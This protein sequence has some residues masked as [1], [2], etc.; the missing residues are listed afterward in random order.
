MDTR[1]LETLIAVIEEGSLAQAARQQSLT[2]ATV[3]QRLRVL[4]EEIG[5]PLVLR[6]GRVVRPTAAATAIVASVRGILRDVEELHSLASGKNVTGQLRLGAVTSGMTGLVPMLLRTMKTDAPEVE[7]YL[8]PGYS[9]E[10]YSAVLNDRLDAAI[11]VR[12]Q[13]EVA[14]TCE[15]E[16]VREDR[17]IVVVP[18]ALAGLDYREALETQPFI[19]YDR[20]QWGGALAE[21]YLRTRNIR[22]RQDFELDSLEAIVV[23]VSEGLGVSLI[24]EWAPPWPEGLRIARLALEQAPRRETVLVWSR[25]PSRTHLIALL[26]NAVAKLPTGVRNLG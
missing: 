15:M 17:L 12:P 4:E 7:H 10:L 6:S 22:P 18:E 24:P 11:I 23:M 2:P 9:G 20:M 25:S 13:F 19:R 8:R 1:F 14:M 3:A 5:E 21:M 16:V 26:R